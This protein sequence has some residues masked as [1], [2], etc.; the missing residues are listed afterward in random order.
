MNRAWLENMAIDSKF[1]KGLRLLWGRAMV[2][3]Y[4]SKPNAKLTGSLASLCRT[5]S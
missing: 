2:E 5:T 1:E 3:E 4:C